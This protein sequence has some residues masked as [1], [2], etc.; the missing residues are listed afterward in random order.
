MEE[1]ASVES[2]DVLIQG[3]AAC[4]SKCSNTWLRCVAFWPKAIFGREILVDRQD[5]VFFA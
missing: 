1:R 3:S 5:G 2:C 4:S